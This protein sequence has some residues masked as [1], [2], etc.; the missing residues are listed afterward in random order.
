MTTD[1][2][3]AELR[4]ALALGLRAAADLRVA[5]G[6]VPAAVEAA[7]NR[8]GRPTT[9]AEAL[10]RHAER[11]AVALSELQDIWGVVLV[12]LPEPD[13]LADRVGDWFERQLRRP[14]KE[15]GRCVMAVTLQHASWAPTTSRTSSRRSK[16][17]R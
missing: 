14:G 16:T 8:F 1:D 11:H 6:A 12:A 17:R 3:L 15:D 13:V 7:L 2:P 4:D 10:R 9:T 5:L